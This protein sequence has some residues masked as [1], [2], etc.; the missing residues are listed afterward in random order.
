LPHDA[1]GPELTAGDLARELERTLSLPPT[2]ERE[3]LSLLIEYITA[4]GADSFSKQRALGVL[5]WAARARSSHHQAADIVPGWDSDLR[6]LFDTLARYAPDV[7]IEHRSRFGDHARDQL[8]FALALVGSGP[9][10]E[11]CLPAVA[12]RYLNCPPGTFPY[13]G[14]LPDTLLVEATVRLLREQAVPLLQWSRI[15]P[16]LGRQDEE[17]RCL[18]LLN[19]CGQDFRSRAFE[20][21]SDSGPAF[22]GPLLRALETRRLSFAGAISAALVLTKALGSEW[23]E[24]LPERVRE[25]LLWD[26]RSGNDVE[27]GISLAAYAQ[28]SESAAGA[29]LRECLRE[30]RAIALI[31]AVKD[32]ELIADLLRRVESTGQFGPVAVQALVACGQRAVA[33][34]LEACGKKSVNPALGAIAAEVLGKF[35]TSQTTAALVALLGHPSKRVVAAAA[36]SL[37]HL[38][39]L[40][41]VELVL[42]AQAAKKAVRTHSE[43]LLA[44]L[45][46][47]QTDATTLLSGV[48]REARAMTAAEREAFVSAWRAAGNSE[49]A[50]HTQLRPRVQQLGAL[51]LELL[52]D[53]LQEKLEEGETRLWCYAVEELRCD[54]VAV[55]VAV[56]TF[57]RMPKLG[58][59]LWARPRR[60][61]SHCGPLLSAPIVHVIKNVRTEYREALYGLLATHARD[62]DPGVFTRGLSDPSKIVR[63]HSVDGLSR[64]TDGPEQEVAMLLEGTEI[65]TRLAAAELLAVWGRRDVADRVATAWANER[66]A[67]V[68]P[69]LEDTLIAC[70]RE[71]LVY[72]LE[73]NSPLDGAAAERFLAGQPLPKKLPSFVVLADL[74]KL[75]FQD[76]SAVS[77]VA[78]RGFLVRLMMLDVTLKGRA[79]RRLL[80]LFDASDVGALSR[81]IYEAWSR[82]RNS[83]HKWAI[84][85]LSLL[86]NDDLLEAAMAELGHWRG[87]EHTA[88]SCHLRAAQWH[89]SETSVRWLGYWSE[90]LASMGG[91]FTAK[92]LLGRVAF[93]RGVS[94]AAL[95]PQLDPFLAEEREERLLERE[96]APG[97]QRQQLLWEIER[98]WLTGRDWSGRALLEL[99]ERQPALGAARYVFSSERGNWYRF[100]PGSAEALERGR[101]GGIDGAAVTL[102]GRF[103]WVHPIDCSR[104]QLDR[105]LDLCGPAAT[106]PGF[107]QFDRATFDAEQLSDLLGLEVSSGPFARWRRKHRWFHGEAMD[108]GIVYTD[109]LHLLAR[110]L[111]ITLHHSGYGI[112]ASD[113]EDDVRLLGLDFADLDGKEVDPGQLPKIVY[114]ELHH[115]ILELCS[116]E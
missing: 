56:D 13:E 15:A 25:A 16:L 35:E 62:V 50:W 114:S 24:H 69:Y 91:R 41:R 110:N 78:R 88:V 64:T 46:D 33:P 39:E 81:W 77:D 113:V 111:L 95:R 1:V 83:K 80:P 104:D 97:Y 86:A 40:A 105:G 74:P 85:Q 3:K 48:R 70:G 7:L 6:L 93:K 52:R 63:T 31:P 71:D 45:S 101:L 21:A 58:A 51:A 92:Q 4:S 59:S 2:S 84:L 89:G 55:W 54:P 90:N 49:A 68:R 109:T 43:R 75:R 99:L 11:A 32:D 26:L 72:G 8:D 61:L 30:E 5:A 116:V 17:F 9:W 108:G 29:L 112:G 100:V 115:N 18:L 10:P 34:L 65:G 23:G 79:L 57:A 20:L 76:G 96:L 28:L 42:G 19:Y 102:D 73:Q 27:A 107:A 22:T 44:K 106:G 60:A 47:K 103:R 38:G 12:R 53:W 82:A 67:K 98:A 36:R 14:M 37:E 87:T 66:S 94:V